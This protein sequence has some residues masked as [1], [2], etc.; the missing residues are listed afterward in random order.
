MAL[1]APEVGKWDPFWELV[2]FPNILEMFQIR[3][4]H[5]MRWCPQVCQDASR[6]PLWGR[7]TAST[8][9]QQLSGPWAHCQAAKP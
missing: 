6:C 2:T 4:T 8:G 3:S 5:S 7:P 1:S 9:W